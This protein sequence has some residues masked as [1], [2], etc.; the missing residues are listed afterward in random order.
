MDLR[1]KEKYHEIHPVKLAADIGSAVG[2][3][4]FLWVQNLLGGLIIGLLPSIITSA[5]IIKWANLEKYKQSSFG[6][7]IEKYMTNT[8]RLIRL[9]GLV[10]ALIGAW[11]H[12]WWLILLGVFI[13]LLAWLRGKILP[14]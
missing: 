6:K 2:F 12:M 14:T 11:F 7:Y 4:Y 13:V 10:V 1:E 8:M 3:M 9:I 5:V